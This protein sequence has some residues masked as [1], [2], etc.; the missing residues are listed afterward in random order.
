VKIPA[1]TRLDA[2]LT[3][4]TWERFSISLVGQNLFKDHHVEFNDV[5]GSIQSGEIKRSAY[6]KITW[7]F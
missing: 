5:S 4:M 6:A 1:Y 7:Q 2:R 3:W